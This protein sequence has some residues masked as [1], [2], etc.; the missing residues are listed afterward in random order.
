MKP[1]GW[2]AE[3][4]SLQ[5]QQ[6]F[7]FKL[8]HSLL[9][10][11][12]VVGLAVLYKT[13]NLAFLNRA[14]QYLSDVLRPN[15]A[16]RTRDRES[17]SYYQATYPASR[18]DG[19]V[20]FPN[21]DSQGAENGRYAVQVASSYDSRKLYAWRDELA[22]DGYETYLVSINSPNGMLF[23]LRVG[24]YDNRPDAEAMRDRLRRRYP[25]NF[26]NSFVMRGN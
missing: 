8:L 20:A 22:A 4:S 18:P 11:A 13:G 16:P 23:K 3:K 9:I 12:I 15:A 6:G 21:E 26:G 25:T 1:A 2:V 19:P 17:S 7:V 14:G 24:S 5:R 10:V